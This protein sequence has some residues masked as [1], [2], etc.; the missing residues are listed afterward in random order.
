MAEYQPGVCNIGKVERRRRLYLGIASFLAAVVFT[1]WVLGT[2]QPFRLL[3]GTFLFVFGGLF[4]YLQYRLEFCVG[5]AALARY[6][7]TGSGDDA[8]TVE[9]ET[10]LFK[11][12]MRAL[13][14]LVV[15]V[16]L[17]GLLTFGVYLLGLF[18]VNPPRA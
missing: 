5:F 2:D 13:Q 11:D 4:G 6:D 10:A 3:A 18:V 9:E 14:I 16:A 8:G 17:A 15:S 7:L 1:G 12:R